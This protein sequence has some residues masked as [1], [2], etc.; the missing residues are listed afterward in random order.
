MKPIALGVTFA[1]AGLFAATVTGVA[2]PGSGAPVKVTCSGGHRL[3]TG[4]Q[5]VVS[6]TTG[7]TGLNATWRVT[8]L[9]STEFTLDGSEA[10]TG[11][12]GGSPAIALAAT[13]ISD[14]A[15]SQPVLMVR[16]EGLTAGKKCVIAIEDTINDF[17]ASIVR[18][19]ISFQGGDANDGQQ[20]KSISARDFPMHRFG[21]ASAKARIRCLDIDSAT[22][23]KVSAWVT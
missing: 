5:V 20:L 13:D 11:T 14:V 1:A 10:L 22:A 17:S 2:L 12:P 4:N 6:G 23:V 21:V 18:H 16:C 3:S 7:V 8:V 19:T 15:H 9:N